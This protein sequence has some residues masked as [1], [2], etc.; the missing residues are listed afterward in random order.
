MVF[1]ILPVT[2]YQAAGTMGRMIEDGAKTVTIMHEQVPVKAHVVKIS[3][4][5]GHKDSDALVNFV[6]QI[7]NEVK[8]VFPVM[9]ET[10]SSLFLAQ[11]LRDYLGVDAYVPSQGEEI[12]L[13]F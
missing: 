5:S 9:G 12:E 7:S 13:E 2:G 6:E 10:S 3:G 1:R 8:K 11:R 4:Y